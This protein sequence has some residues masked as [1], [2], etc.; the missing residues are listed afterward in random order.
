MGALDTL[1]LVGSMIVALA[2]GGCCRCSNENHEPSPAT[3]TPN[4]DAGQAGDGDRFSKRYG[5]C[6]KTI[7]DHS[8]RQL[9]NVNRFCTQFAT[10][11]DYGETPNELGS[12]FRDEYVRCD[13]EDTDLVG[14]IRRG[15]N[16][17][18]THCA[19]VSIDGEGIVISDFNDLNF[20]TFGGNIVWDFYM[21]AV[22]LGL[23]LCV[24]RVLLYF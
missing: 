22:L 15:L 5:M 1:R 17:P 14:R 23:R 9:S 18:L 2:T 24:C 12:F 13:Y 3:P 7:T 4:R 21:M 6:N 10:S 19:N 16:I 11:R 8:K 20:N